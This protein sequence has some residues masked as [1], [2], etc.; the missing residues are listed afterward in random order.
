M[1]IY[2]VTIGGV[3]HYT[4]DFARVEALTAQAVEDGK[5]Y[6]VIARKGVRHDRP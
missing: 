2:T 6:T 5:S 3:T 1:T 4:S